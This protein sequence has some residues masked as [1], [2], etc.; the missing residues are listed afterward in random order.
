MPKIAHNACY[1]EKMDLAASLQ[2][3]TESEGD[4]YTGATESR[5]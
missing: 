3:G 4:M 2:T 1:S 5:L